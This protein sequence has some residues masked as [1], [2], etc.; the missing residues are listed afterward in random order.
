MRVMHVISGLATGG[1]EL[2]LVKL[3]RSTGS[4]TT[5]FDPVV[6]SVQGAG[7]VA[8]QLEEIGVP[9]EAVGLRT[10]ASVPAALARLAGVARR[11][12]P[13]LIQG[14]M[15]HGNAAALVIRALGRGRPPVLWN[16][17]QSIDAL[18]EEKR[19]TAFLI[20]RGVPLSRRT[21]GI[22]YNSHHSAQQ[23]EALGYAADRRHIIANGFET[24]RFAPSPALRAQVRTELGIGDDAPLVGLLA[25]Y[26]PMKDHAT[27]LAAAARLAAVRPDVRFVLAGHGVDFGNPELSRCIDELALRDHVFLLGERADTPA[28]HAALDIATSSSRSEGFPNVL[29]EAMACGVPCVATDVGDSRWV[30]G[31]C[32]LMVPP[33]EP[34]ALAAAWRTLLERSAQER[35][36]LG[37]A[38]RTRIREHFSID[39]VAAAY[40]ALY[41]S[42]VA[43]VAASSSG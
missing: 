4:R 25:R 10:P 33:R 34:A 40:A 32:G 22:I 28:L 14:W 18:G 3:L 42:T 27:F 43:R 41:E 16:I 7:P 12:Q 9:I 20:R 30:V 39:R 37:K 1:A 23:H 26:H 24:D 36:R 8:R 17:R 19:A 35:R 15:Y 13:D 29:G 31:D 21:V 11:H 6:V 38:G 2:M 5:G